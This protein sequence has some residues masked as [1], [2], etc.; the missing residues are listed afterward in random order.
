MIGDSELPRGRPDGDLTMLL[1]GRG[2]HCL[3]SSPRPGCSRRSSPSPRPHR[4]CRVPS[5][6]RISKSVLSP[7]ADLGSSKYMSSIR[8]GLF[9]EED[10][11]LEE[12][13]FAKVGGRHSGPGGAVMLTDGLPSADATSS[14][15]LDAPICPDVPLIS[16]SPSDEFH[17]PKCLTSAAADL[18][19]GGRGRAVRLQAEAD[20]EAGGGAAPIGGGSGCRGQI[21]AVRW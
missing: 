11:I 2:L 6:P 9:E 4:R 21:W 14:M 20:S 17:C 10:L 15:G 3:S 12:E 7:V 18:G 5:P 8:E 1:R 16:V 13:E 19:L